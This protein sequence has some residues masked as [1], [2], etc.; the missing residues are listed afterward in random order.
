MNLTK[1]QKILLGVSAVTLLILIILVA[2]I[3]IFS[4][5][6]NNPESNQQEDLVSYTDIPS[7]TTQP[8][9]YNNSNQ[10]IENQSKEIIPLNADKLVKTISSNEFCSLPNTGVI[11]YQYSTGDFETHNQNSKS[12]I[13]NNKNKVTGYN[14]EAD[15][16]EVIEIIDN[17]KDLTSFSDLNAFSVWCSGSTGNY[18]K[19]YVVN[20]PSVD[21]SIAYI[22]VGGIQYAWTKLSDVKFTIKVLAQKGD[23]VI[24][25]SEYFEGA[26]ILTQEQVN[27]CQ[28]DSGYGYSY[29][30]LQCLGN[31]Y[32]ESQ[33]IQEE[34]V[35]RTKDL[36][37]FFEF[38]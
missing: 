2:L 32:L 24:Q 26:E 16:A 14:K 20:Y 23:N 9:S 34:V 33:S 37:K 36:I 22:Y 1:K 18:I 4:R 10:N 17:K 21:K 27:S 13:I 7:Y 19:S 12:L 15:F 38:K 25:L 6:N 5:P 31:L 3:L 29:L 35:Q 30:S 8:L 28:T 11:A